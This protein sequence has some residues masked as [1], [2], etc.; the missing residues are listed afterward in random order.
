MQWPRKRPRQHSPRDIFE[1][2]D[3]FNGILP[4]PFAD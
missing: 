4:N 2:D 3:A 1:M